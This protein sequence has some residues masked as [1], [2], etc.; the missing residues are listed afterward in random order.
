MFAPS[1][2]ALPLPAACAGAFLLAVSGDA[3]ASA[4]L[5]ASNWSFSGFATVGVVHADR[6]QADYVASIMKGNG[7]GRSAR[8]SRH[9]DSKVGGQLDLQIGSAW[10]A[11]L[12]VVSEQRAD[13]RY[14]P[15]VEWANVKYQL[16]PELALRVG[17]IALPMFMAADYRKVGYAYPWVR[18]P[19]EVYGV[20][21]LTN[22]DGIDLSWRWSQAGFNGNTQLLAGR[23]VTPLFDGA[24]LRG[25][26]IG[27]LSHTVERGAFSARASFITAR[28]TVDLYPA[29]FAA[30]DDFGAEGSAAKRSMSMDN[31]RATALSLGLNYDPGSWFLMG[32]AGVSQV[33]G[34][35][36]GTRSAYLSGGW[37]HGSLTPYA[38]YARVHARLPGGP[39]QLALDG[40]H[41]LQAATGALVNGAFAA[42][43]QAVPAQA[44]IGAGLRWDLV[45]NTALKLQ[46]ERVRTGH[47]SRGMFINSAPQYQSGRSVHVTSVSVDVVF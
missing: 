23:T 35:L 24:H 5:D 34:Y 12:Q 17:R 43:L 46:H 10:S 7:A 31:K 4:G 36:G 42:M 16:S 37:R 38:S 21:P 20:L 8:W 27:G 2:A 25:R 3:L 47:G 15:R 30:L 32:E 19:L 6:R 13:Y 9:V 28:L 39:T 26:A 45:A 22:S 11:V 29:L 33:D 1:P 40:L 14:T 41:P 44:S 18:T